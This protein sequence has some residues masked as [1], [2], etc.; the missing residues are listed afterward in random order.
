MKINI[1]AQRQSKESS[2]D[3]QEK[4]KA[5]KY[6]NNIQAKKENGGENA[7]NGKI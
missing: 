1:L 4:N 7:S 5:D 2:R 6:N 3:N